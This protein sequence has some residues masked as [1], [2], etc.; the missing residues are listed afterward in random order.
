MAAAGVVY[1][2]RRAAVDAPLAVSKL[3]YM[4]ATFL[5]RFHAC[6]VTCSSQASFRLN[7]KKKFDDPYADYS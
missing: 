6:Q 5:K 1:A 3:A 4:R 7:L 2:E